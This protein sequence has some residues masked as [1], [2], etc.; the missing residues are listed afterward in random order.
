VAG[1]IGH[2]APAT[3]A[4]LRALGLSDGLDDAAA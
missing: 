3:V 2:P 4:C 1:G